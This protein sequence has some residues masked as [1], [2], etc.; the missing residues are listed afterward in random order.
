MS[1]PKILASA[2]GGAA[3]AALSFAGS[4]SLA[5]GAGPFVG[6]AGSWSGGGTVSLSSGASE[7]IRCRATYAGGGAA[8]QMN[9]R[10]ASASYNFNLTSNVQASGN[11]IS[12]SWTETSRGASGSVSG[13]ASGGQIQARVSGPTFTANL[14]VSTRGNSQSIV[15]RSAGTELTGVNISLSRS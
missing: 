5:Q 7:R 1:S 14:A 4:P 10:C 13:S 8:L 15:I 6:L 11:A 2:L 12:G 9:L 3:L